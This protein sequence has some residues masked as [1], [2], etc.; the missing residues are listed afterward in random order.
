ME[1]NSMTINFVCGLQAGVAMTIITNPIFV[2]KTRM[3]TSSI[4]KR[5]K[6]F[7]SGLIKLGK[8]E[9]LRGMYRGL[10]P[11]LPLTAHAAL[12]WTLFELFKSLIRSRPERKRSEMNYFETMITASG[13]KIGVS[14]FA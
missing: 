10:L 8:E 4:D 7:I 2:V 1:S 6:G 13:S 3:Q 14:K 9:G 11:A 12:H 5:Y